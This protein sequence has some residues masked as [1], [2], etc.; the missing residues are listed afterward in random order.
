MDLQTVP[1]SCLSQSHDS[2]Q[3]TA[4]ELARVPILIFLPEPRANDARRSE[5]R[6]AKREGVGTRHGDRAPAG[7]A[8]GA[9]PLLLIGERGTTPNPPPALPVLAVA[10]PPPPPPPVPL[11]GVSLACAAAAQRLA[12]HSSQWGAVAKRKVCSEG[13]PA[14]AEHC[15]A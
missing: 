12:A 5:R 14:D 11:S 1:Q 3:E 15:A 7:A 9:E 4:A 10:P 2:R 13:A 6:R 8:V